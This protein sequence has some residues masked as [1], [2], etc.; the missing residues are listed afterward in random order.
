MGMRVDA[1][2][3]D[4]AAGSVEVVVGGFLQ[5]LADGDDLAMLD[6]D[7]GLDR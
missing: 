3:H 4:V 2:R 5:V 1:A 6:E 7:V